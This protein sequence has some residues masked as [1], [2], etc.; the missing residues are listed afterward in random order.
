MDFFLQSVPASHSLLENITSL[1]KVTDV[2]SLPAQ[3]SIYGIIRVVKC[4]GA[5][6]S[7]YTSDFK[8]FLKRVLLKRV[9]FLFLIAFSSHYEM[10]GSVQW[11]FHMIPISQ[12]RCY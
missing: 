2:A 4:E 12:M 5:F 9:T 6:S 7:D 11:Y 10:T 8:N 1:I 3:A